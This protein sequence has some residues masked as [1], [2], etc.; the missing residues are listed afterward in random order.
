M[1]FYWTLLYMMNGI[2][3]RETMTTAKEQVCIIGRKMGQSVKGETVDSDRDWSRKG[4]TMIQGVPMSV[5]IIRHDLLITPTPLRQPFPLY[6]WISQGRVTS[7]IVSDKGQDEWRSRDK[8]GIGKDDW[9]RHGTPW[10]RL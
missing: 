5:M 10:D 8:H 6:H 3:T 7:D 4:G 1:T 2:A 9:G